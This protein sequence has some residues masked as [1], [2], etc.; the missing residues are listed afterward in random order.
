MVKLLKI[1]KNLAPLILLLLLPGAIF[2]FVSPLPIYAFAYFSPQALLGISLNML[3]HGDWERWLISVIYALFF[4]SLAFFLRIQW[5]DRDRERMV[6]RTGIF[7]LGV[8]LGWLIR[9]ISIYLVIIIFWSISPIPY[10]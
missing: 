5:R 7:V 6:K 10:P 1:K 3:K 2:G 4:G 8:G 9:E